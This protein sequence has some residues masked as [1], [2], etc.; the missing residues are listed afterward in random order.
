[1]RLVKS[2]MQKR[3]WHEGCVAW[4]LCIGMRVCVWCQ[5]SLVTGCPH[6]ETTQKYT[7]T[8]RSESSFVAM[9]WRHFSIILS[10]RAAL[11]QA[12]PRP[13]SVLMWLR[14]RRCVSSKRRVMVIDSLLTLQQHRD[15][16]LITSRILKGSTFGLWSSW[17]WMK[18]TECSTW[19]L[20][21]R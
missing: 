9:V 19:I 2:P 5:H 11:S 10:L 1:M 13:T 7:G 12:H 21:Q 8:Y 15:V 18:Q 16:W 3:V 20:R 17:L 4:G 14:D 6:K